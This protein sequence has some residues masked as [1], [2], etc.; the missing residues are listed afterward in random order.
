M[1][2]PGILKAA[3]LLGVSY[4]VG[5]L[6]L[7]LLVIR[8]FLDKECHD[9]KLLFYEKAKFSL[10]VFVTVI[11]VSGFFMLYLLDF[12]PPPYIWL[13]IVFAIVAITL[14]FISPYIVKKAPKGSVHYIYGIVLA[15]ALLVLVLGASVG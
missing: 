11:F 15:L 2:S 12:N 13:K 7:D 6:L 4:F 8:S 10:H 14:F 5:F 1:V 3:H 9:K